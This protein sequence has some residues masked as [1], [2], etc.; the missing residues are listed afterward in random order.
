MRRLR[1][2]ANIKTGNRDTVDRVDSGQYPFFVRSQTVERINTWAFDGE[3]VLT[4]G[5]GAGVAKVFHYVNGRFD[6]HQRV[7][8]FSEFHDVLGMF[9]FEYFRATLRFEALAGN[10]KSTVDSLRRPMLQNFPVVVPPKEEQAAVVRYLGRVAASIEATVSHAR[11]EIALLREY[12][13]RLIA[14][15]VSGKLDVREAA[16]RLPDEGDDSESL[17]ESEDDTEQSGAGESN[18]VSAEEAEA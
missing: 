11:D 8:K 15:V 6:Y 16:A 18:D 13:T 12:R 7:Y 14:D 17:D 10:A 5:D 1:S 9:F 4:A 3:A 2:I